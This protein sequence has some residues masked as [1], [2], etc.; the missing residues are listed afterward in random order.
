[1][2]VARKNTWDPCTIVAPLVGEVRVTSETGPTETVTAVEVT[3]VP[4]ESKATA[5]IVFDPPTVGVHAIVYGAV[6]TGAPIAT[7]ALPGGV[8]KNDTDVIVAPAIAAAD[9]DRVTGVPRV[10]LELLAGAVSDTE[11]AVTAVMVTVVEFA[12]APLVSTTR[13]VRLN[14]P[15]E[16]GTQVVE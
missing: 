7:A 10:A 5:V 8:T 14:V 9:A 2:G 15:A 16:V 3:E 6:V 13:A 11:V 1:V 12:I 4:F